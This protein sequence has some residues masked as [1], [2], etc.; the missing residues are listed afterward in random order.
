MK[1]LIVSLILLMGLSFNANAADP[2]AFI[3]A[4]AMPVAFLAFTAMTDIKYE[5]CNDKPYRT[6]QHKT[7]SNYSFSVTECDYQKNKD[8]YK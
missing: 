4:G 8:S 7:G 6:V 3:S 5:A 2:S 1:K